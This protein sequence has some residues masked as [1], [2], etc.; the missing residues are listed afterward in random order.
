FVDAIITQMVRGI[1]LIH[2]NARLVICDGAAKCRCVQRSGNA[3]V[4]LR[5]DIF[6]KEIPSDRPIE[7]TRVDINKTELLGKL[8][9]NA[10]FSRRS[11]AINGNHTTR[12]SVGS[13][14]FHMYFGFG[15]PLA[16][17]CWRRSERADYR[18]ADLHAFRVREFLK[19]RFESG[20]RFTNTF[21][22]LDDGLAFGEKARYG[23]GH[24]DAMI[25][26]AR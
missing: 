1:D 15:N 24:R 18:R 23:K 2:Q 17:L 21:R 7:S 5:P 4:L 11:G 16:F 19:D 26:K 13:M 25:A 12:A 20:I 22:V 6:S 10:A 14:R 8:S 3:I 9:R